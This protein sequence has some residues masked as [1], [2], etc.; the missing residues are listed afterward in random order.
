MNSEL[1]KLLTIY[2]A[3]SPRLGFKASVPLKSQTSFI[4]RINYR[5]KAKIINSIFAQSLFNFDNS[6]IYFRTFRYFQ[7]IKRQF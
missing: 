4:L 2:K 3:T 7:Y 1:E 6:T 5:L